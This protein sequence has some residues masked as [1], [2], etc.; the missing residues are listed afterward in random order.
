MKQMLTVTDFFNLCCQK[1]SINRIKLQP[2][3][4]HTRSN[5]N[6]LKAESRPEQ[7]SPASERTS[8]SQQTHT[9]AESVCVCV[10]PGALEQ[11]LDLWKMTSPGLGG[12][13]MSWPCLA[14]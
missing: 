4:K 10:L 11:L 6:E 3:A 9:R 5:R 1:A 12:G 7:V 8:E 2:K 13:V 14:S